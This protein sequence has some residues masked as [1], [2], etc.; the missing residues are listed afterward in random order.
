MKH[1]I[2]AELPKGRLQVVT[3][4]Q[5]TPQGIIDF[6]NDVI[7]HPQWK[8]G[9]SLLVDHRKLSLKNLDRLDTE[10]VVDH[11]VNI[12]DRLGSGKCA[13]VMNRDVDFGIARASEMMV[14]N[15]TDMEIQVFRSMEEAEKWLGPAAG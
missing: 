12:R 10:T 11:F 14:S 5:G 2:E 7:S 3:E 6:L 4:G 1:R 8:S 9:M 15:R 13:L